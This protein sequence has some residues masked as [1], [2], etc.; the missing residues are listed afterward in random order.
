M[1]T[2]GP[3]TSYEYDDENQLTAVEF[4]DPNSVDGWRSEF[5]YD[6]KLRMRRHLTYSRSVIAG[7]TYWNL[8]SEWR[9]VYDGMLVVQERS[10]SNVPTVTYTRGPDLSGTLQGAG[11]IGGMLGRS[12]GYSTTTGAWSSHYHYHA[13]GNGNITYM[14]SPIESLGA[15]YKYDPF[16]N[17][18]SSSGPG[19]SANLYRFS[20]KMWTGNSALYYY[21]YRFYNPTLQRW[22]NRDPIKELGGINLYAYVANNPITQLDPFGLDYV[23]GGYP[24]WPPPIPPSKPY[25][26]PSPKPKPCE[27]KAKDPAPC[28]SWKETK[29]LTDCLM[30]CTQKF[31]QKARIPGRKGPGWMAWL[32]ACKSACMASE[33]AIGPQ[34]PGP[35][36][37]PAVTP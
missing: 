25:F 32:H 35:D 11:G 17:L 21:G 5:I 6:G 16:G 19:S 24:Y 27:P 37:K 15:S 36:G 14:V 12:H 4:S 30:C 34:T 18:I 22:M 20:S 26:P 33:G 23:P 28:E 8:Y 3:S 13:D 9:M 1:L 31:S 2:F 10:S 29:D 7:T